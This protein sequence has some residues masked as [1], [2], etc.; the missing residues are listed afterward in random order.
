[1]ILFLSSSIFGLVLTLVLQKRCRVDYGSDNDKLE[2][3]LAELGKVLTRQRETD[4]GAASSAV[5]E[6][7]E[8]SDLIDFVEPVVSG[9]Q[10]TGSRL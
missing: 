1:M 10:N 7:S 8:S 2:R 5:S 9:L 6:R 3:M 4:L